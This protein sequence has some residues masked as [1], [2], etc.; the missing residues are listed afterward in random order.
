MSRDNQRIATVLTLAGITPI[1]ILLA[2][3][4]LVFVDT[5]ALAA[6]GYGAVIASFVCGVHWGLFMARYRVMPFNL[7]VTSNVG[8]L[9][10]WAMLLLGQVSLPTG[11]VG[12]ALVLAGLLALDWRLVQRGGIAPWFWRLRWMAT[13]GLGL[14][15]L[16]WG[17]SI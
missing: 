7:L 5:L 4:P 2:L 8:A 13:A 14:G 6:L 16:V 15:L 11:F 12:L 10:A 9:A 1:W 3:R 17:I